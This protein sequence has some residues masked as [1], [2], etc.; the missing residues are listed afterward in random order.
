VPYSDEMIQNAVSDGVVQASTDRD[1]TDFEKRYGRVNIRDFDSN[2]N[3]VSEMD[4]LIAYLQ[5]LGTM[6]DFSKYEPIKLQP[7]EQPKK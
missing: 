7:K 3:K 5:V 6:V 2:I 1:T 4:A